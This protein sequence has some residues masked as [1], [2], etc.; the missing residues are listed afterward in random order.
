M[1]VASMSP[2]LSRVGLAFSLK[3]W[4]INV[5]LAAL[6][7]EHMG[8]SESALPNLELLGPSKS[9]MAAKA[10]A[11]VEGLVLVLCAPFHD[12]KE[13]TSDRAQNTCAILACSSCHMAQIHLVSCTSGTQGQPRSIPLLLHSDDTSIQDTH[14]TPE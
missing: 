5:C 13:Q 1:L 14:K 11:E 9:A 6:L 4:A 10:E 7:C 2:R 12:E 3:V 8:Y